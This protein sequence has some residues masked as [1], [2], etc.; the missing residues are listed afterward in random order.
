M[1]NANTAFL[2]SFVNSSKAKCASTANV[3][4]TSSLG[5]KKIYSHDDLSK[6]DLNNNEN[7]F[8]KL[9]PSNWN[10]FSLD[11]YYKK[12]GYLC[13]CVNR[14]RLAVRDGEISKGETKKNNVY[15]TIKRKF[16]HIEGARGVIT[17]QVF[18][19]QKD[20]EIL[21]IEINPR[22]GGGYPLSHLAGAN[23]PELIIKD[24]PN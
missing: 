16:N 19:D 17:L 23:F 9:V 8:Q 21:G 10:E 12:N 4:E 15:E 6:S 11:M 2:F 22:F 1:V 20:Q 13:S 24:I 14:L 5:I 3:S 18:A 7:I